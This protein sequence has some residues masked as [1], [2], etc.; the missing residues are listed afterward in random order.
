VRFEGQSDPD[1]S[2]VLFALAT[3]DD[4][5]RGTF[6]AAYGPQMDAATAAAVEGLEVIPEQRR[7]HAGPAPA[8]GDDVRP[9]LLTPWIQDAL[10]AERFVQSNSDHLLAHEVLTADTQ[11]TLLIRRIS[12]CAHAHGEAIERLLESR[13]ESP[14]AI[15]AALGAGLGSTLGLLA[16]LPNRDIEQ[17]VRDVYVALNYT[18]G[19]YHVLYTRARLQDRSAEADLAL[20][21]LRDYTPVIRQLSHVM[22]WVAALGVPP[23]RWEG[24]PVMNEIVGTLLESWNSDVDSR[25]DPEEAS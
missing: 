23:D 11:A 15:R 10:S 7:R 14:S 12:Q 21:H 16:R 9:E 2:A 25:P 4:R 13:D 8:E 18:A 20:R 6:V 1:D 17:I 22:A 3:P 24:R 5:F 19:G